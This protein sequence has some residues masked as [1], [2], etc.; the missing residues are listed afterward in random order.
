MNFRSYSRILCAFTVS[1]TYSQDTQILLSYNS[2]NFYVMQHAAFN[3]LHEL[4]Y[5]D[6]IYAILD[7]SY[8]YVCI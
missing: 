5:E 4:F 2:H 8:M 7:V 6:H 3:D 1:F